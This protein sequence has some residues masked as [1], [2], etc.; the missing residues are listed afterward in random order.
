[1]SCDTDIGT[2]QG[3]SRNLEARIP[4]S[5][6]ETV[7]GVR[8]AP[9]DRYQPCRIRDRAAHR[10]GETGDAAAA[11]DGLAGQLA[12]PSQTVPPRIRVSTIQT[13]S[14]LASAIP[15]WRWS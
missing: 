10:A 6:E 2:L 12:R 5:G 3:L 7:V 15:D 14:E 9:I 13:R 8:I 1:M 4:L 11:I